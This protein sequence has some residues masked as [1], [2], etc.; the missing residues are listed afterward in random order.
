[1]NKERSTKRPN[2]FFLFFIVLIIAVGSFFGGALYG[3]L[4]KA[5]I[6]NGTPTA[7]D[8]L[9]LKIYSMDSIIR[10]LIKTPF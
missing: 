3:A 7:G 9:K 6:L 2:R 5:M 4:N 8:D 1:M 10:K